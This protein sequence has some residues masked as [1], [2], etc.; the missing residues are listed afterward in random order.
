MFRRFTDEALI[1]EN[2]VWPNF[3]L[4]IFFFALKGSK[5]LIIICC[6]CNWVLCRVAAVKNLPALIYS[7]DYILLLV[8]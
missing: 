1:A 2:A 4:M 8:L 5:L 6:H 7:A 3:F